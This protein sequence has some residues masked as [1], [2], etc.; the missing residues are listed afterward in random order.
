MAE[1]GIDTEKQ[2]LRREAPGDRRRTLLAGQEVSTPD[3]KV[4]RR[5]PEPPRP[6]ARDPDPGE[7]PR[8]DPPP[9]PSSPGEPP[10]TIEDPHPEP[11]TRKIVT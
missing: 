11:P 2:R 6:P 3:P 5:E 10:P 1:Y 4:P 9:E 8:G 7:P